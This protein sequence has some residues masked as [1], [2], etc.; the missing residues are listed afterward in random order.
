MHCPVC[1]AESTQG[2][3]YCKRCG[4]GLGAATGDLPVVYGR[5][6]QLLW[7]VALVSIVGL[8]AFFA[9]IVGLSD[10]KI[11]VR[12]IAL[13][14]VFGGFTVV[15]VVGLLIALLSKMISPS[16]PST[17]TMNPRVRAQSEA[18]RQRIEAERPR[19][20]EA[21]RASGASVTENTSRNF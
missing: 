4:A 13:V 6:F 18:E 11:D 15:G 2:L 10:M 7:P 20:S 21:P 14:A 16:R 19:I 9:T 17:H 12:T 8:I 5:P 1:G 3:N